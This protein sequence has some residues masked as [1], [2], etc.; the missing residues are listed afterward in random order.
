VEKNITISKNSKLVAFFEELNKRKEETRKKLEAKM[1]SKG[2]IPN[3]SKI[4]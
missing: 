3:N 4:A 2:L 1:I